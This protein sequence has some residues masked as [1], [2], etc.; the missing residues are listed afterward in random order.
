[1]NGRP[2]IGQYKYTLGADMTFGESIASC[3]E[4]YASFQGRASRSEYWYFH[5]FVFLYIIA[6][7]IV[8]AIL[9]QV[10]S[11]LGGLLTLV[12][13]LAIIAPSISVMVRRLHDTNRS[14]WFYWIG[15]IPLV[16]GIILLVMFC[17]RGTAGPNNYGD[18]PLGAG[19]GD[20]FR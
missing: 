15:L 5:L 10:S 18:D 11:V 4:Q 2:V 12:A 14:G 20:T 16:G 8:G 3:K 19:F 1:M 9:M 7:E 17:T 6:V 13:M